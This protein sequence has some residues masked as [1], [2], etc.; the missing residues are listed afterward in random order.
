[1]STKIQINSLPALLHL[2]EAEGDVAVEIRRSVLKEYE[3]KHVLPTVLKQ[4]NETV[5]HRV[6]DLL[7]E[8]RSFGRFLVKPAYKKVVKALVEER[9]EALVKGLVAKAVKDAVTPEALEQRVSQLVQEVS[10]REVT[11]QVKAKIAEV[12]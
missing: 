2:L 6:N 3:T 9:I 7:F 8:Q 11:K 1:M 10:F 12:L 5:T 4:I